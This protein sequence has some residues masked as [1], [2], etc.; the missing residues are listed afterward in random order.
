MVYQ[1][2]FVFRCS[3]MWNLILSDIDSYFVMCSR[4]FFLTSVFRCIVF[5]ML[6]V[7]CM[8]IVSVTFFTFFYFLIFFLFFSF[9]TSL[10]SDVVCRS[11]FLYYFVLMLRFIVLYLCIFINVVALFTKVKPPF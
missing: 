3:V 8:W 10:D 6:T 7:L 4:L 9:V 5:I 11:L 1:V 2:N